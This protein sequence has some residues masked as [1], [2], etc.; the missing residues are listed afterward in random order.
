M[1]EKLQKIWLRLRYFFGLADSQKQTVKKVIMLV[2][3]YC[4]LALT[5]Q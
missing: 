5:A 4:L 3:K 2:W 1:D